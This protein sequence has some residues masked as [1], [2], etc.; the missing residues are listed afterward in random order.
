MSQQIRLQA[1]AAQG[2]TIT[3]ANDVL[4]VSYG[5]LWFL[6]VSSGCLMLSYGTHMVHGGDMAFFLT[7]FRRPCAST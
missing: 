3:R 1:H 5:F 7:K 4:M 2:I 6:M